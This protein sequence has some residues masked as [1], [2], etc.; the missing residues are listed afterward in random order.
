MLSLYNSYYN[1]CVSKIQNTSNSVKKGKWT[2]SKDKLV[3][4][5]AMLTNYII[6][7]FGCFVNINI[8]ISLGIIIIS[9]DS[10]GLL[11]K[12]THIFSFSWMS[13]SIS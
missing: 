1:D 10:R 6:F 5:E 8:N 4:Q 9:V 3:K 13:Y 12:F 2:G 7:C 11:F